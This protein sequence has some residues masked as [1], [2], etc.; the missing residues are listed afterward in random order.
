MKSKL[1]QFG[2]LVV[3]IGIVCV[4]M[5]IGGIIDNQKTPVAYE[6]L[7]VSQ[8]KSGMIVDGNISFNLGAFEE[9]YNTKYGIKTGSSQYYY[10]IMVE[11]KVMAL[12]TLADGTVGEALDKQASEFLDYAEDGDLS[13]SS[14]VAIKG[15][16]KK[17]D[18]ETQDYLE[19]YLSYGG[20]M[21]FEISPY[22]IETGVMDKTSS[23]VVTV[24]GA[25]CII[26]PLLI[27]LVAVKASSRNSYGGSYS[28]D[29]YGSASGT[30]GSTASTGS[31]SFGQDFDE[32]ERSLQDSDN[33]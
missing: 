9:S 14:G 20:E 19:D 29:G 2:I 4:V 23:I 26:I 17:M 33:R 12:K 3:I 25:V 5:G 1:K 8:L 11:D 7:K 21:L 31:T 15:K 22:V 30:Y 16:V 28:A 6:N 10:A 18:S 32:Y 13:L 27:M 24:I